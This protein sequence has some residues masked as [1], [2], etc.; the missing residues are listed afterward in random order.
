MKSGRSK[1]T[2]LLDMAR[3]LWFISDINLPGSQNCIADALSHWH[4]GLAVTC[5]CVGWQTRMGYTTLLVFS[6]HLDSDLKSI[7]HW[8]KVPTLGRQLHFSSLH[9]CIVAFLR[10]F[11]LLPDLQFR[12][13]RKLFYNMLTGVYSAFYGHVVSTLVLADSFSFVSSALQTLLLRSTALSWHIWPPRWDNV[14]NK[15]LDQGPEKRLASKRS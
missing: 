1:D 12:C 13:Y 9:F 8:I 11:H 2:L 6:Y 4:Q 15:P 3:E 5:S 7:H 14:A 10:T